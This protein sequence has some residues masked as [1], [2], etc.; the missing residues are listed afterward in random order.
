[1]ECLVVCLPLVK[2]AMTLRSLL[3]A[4]IIIFRCELGAQ[5]IIPDTVCTG[6]V[7]NAT[8]QGEPASSYCIIPNTDYFSQGVEVDVVGDFPEGSFPLF[9]H[10]AVDGDEHYVFTTISTNGDLVRSDFGNSFANTPTTTIITLDEIPGGQEGIQIINDNGHWWGF[11]IGGNIDFFG[12]E[13]LIR[14][15]FGDALT[16]I[17]TV[18]NLG[19]IGSLGFPHDLFIVKENDEWIGLTVNRSSNTI[20]R[21][22]F[23]DSLENVPVATNLGNIG[24]LFGPTGFY[25]IQVEGEWHLFVVNTNGNSLSRVDFGDSFLNMPTGVNLGGAGQLKVPRDVVI[26]KVCDN[27]IG[28][29]GNRTEGEIIVIGLGPDI[30]NSFFGIIKEKFQGVS[31]PHAFS[32]LSI[33]SSGVTGFVVDVENSKLNRVRFNTPDGAIQCAGHLEEIELSYADPGNYMIQVITDEG[34]PS[35][36][37]FCK[38]IV[39]IPSAE[40]DLGA[41]TILCLGETLILESEYPQTVWLDEVDVA[42]V[43]GYNFE[44]TTSGI[45]QATVEEGTCISRDSIYVEFDD[46]EQCFLFPNIFA[47]TQDT[48][49]EFA[50][51]LNCD[52]EILDYGLTVY[53]RW[54]HP[55]FYSDDFTLA[56]R[57]RCREAFCLPGVY[58]WHLFFSYAINGQIQ[59]RVEVGTVTLVR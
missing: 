34:L 22:E 12:E 6:E 14:L 18:E 46:C 52:A 39:V 9:S 44:V 8:F 42:Q 36:S 50:S 43:D 51:I 31:Y 1:L 59:E 15:D 40:L 11:V 58:A 49:N 7:F 21:F 54:G 5:V 19:N 27:Y 10:S 23:G 38:N 2:M 29:V 30:R 48:D 25:P 53:D 55:V 20:T 17:P 56:W 26:T 57:G 33:T 24:E 3:F 32:S 28:L 4:V 35:Q 13:Y 37:G 47:P 45:V 16:N 41:D